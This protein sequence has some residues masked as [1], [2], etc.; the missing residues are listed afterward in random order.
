MAEKRNSGGSET[1]IDPVAKATSRTTPPAA[2]DDSYLIGQ[3]TSQPGLEPE[4]IPSAAQR[5]DDAK[6]AASRKAVTQTFW[7]LVRHQ[8]KKNRIAVLALYVVYFL[9]GLAIFADLLANDKPLFT[10]YNGEIYFPVFRQY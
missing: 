3:Q 10:K 1:Q 7:S 9:F 4:E 8:F 5:K 2:G 6:R